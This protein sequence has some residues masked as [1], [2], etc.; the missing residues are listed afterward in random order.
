MLSLG[1]S[2]KHPLSSL[3]LSP[4]PLAEKPNR[5]RGNFSLRP[6]SSSRNSPAQI[7]PFV[8]LLSRN[9]PRIN[10]SKKI[11]I[12]HISLI[13]HHLNP[14]RINTSKNKDL[15]P[16]RINT[17]GAKDLKSRRI[18][19]SKKHRRGEGPTHGDLYLYFNY[20]EGPSTTWPPRFATPAAFAVDS[21]AA[22]KPAV[23]RSRIEGGSLLGGS[24]RTCSS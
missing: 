17:S 24:N 13:P 9:S 2:C 7:Q 5:P 3:N 14:T 11:S 15:K 19:T 20:T 1:M 16:R 23:H 21:L 22:P 8:H 18:N 10:T 4:I 6:Q 12:S